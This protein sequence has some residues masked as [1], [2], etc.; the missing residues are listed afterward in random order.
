MRWECK[1]L[2]MTESGITPIGLGTERLDSK[3]TSKHWDMVVQD[4]T[5]RALSQEKDKLP[6]LSGLARAFFNQF[7]DDYLAGLWKSTLVRG[8][9]WGTGPLSGEGRKIDCS[10]PS[11]Y[12]APSWSWAS[13]EGNV[14]TFAGPSNAASPQP[15]E[16]QYTE[17]LDH[18]VRVVGFDVFGQVSWGMIVLRGPLNHI[19]HGMIVASNGHWKLFGDVGGI[20]KRV[21][22]VLDLPLYSP[23]AR[24]SDS[25]EST[26][27]DEDDIWCLR[28]L[29]SS[30]LILRKLSNHEGIY[31]RI[32]KMRVEDRSLMYFDSW[33]KQTVS[34][35]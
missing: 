24:N 16:N 18:D 17:L 21:S 32:G 15:F 10:R 20:V 9:L 34:I 29:S 2:K 28:T 33:E 8:L 22:I 27:L 26:P 25:T 30:A 1:S 3:L 31:E 7:G 5:C 23:L 19:E 6:A 12:R 11:T 13:V 14:S 4:Y 35:I